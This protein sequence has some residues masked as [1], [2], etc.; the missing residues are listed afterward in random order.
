VWAGFRAGVAGRPR[1]IKGVMIR[2]WHP[3]T[4]DSKM[5]VIPGKAMLVPVEVFPMAAVI[6]AGHRLRI[7]ISASNQAE[8]VWPVPQQSA[9][10][11]GVSTIYNDALRPSSVVLPV[12]PAS[13]LN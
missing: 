8:G 11:G 4:V 2:P 5:A 13:Q 7:A 3:F 12:V 9:A 10:N 1:Y 6:K